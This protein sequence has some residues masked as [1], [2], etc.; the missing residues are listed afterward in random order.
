MGWIRQLKIR[1]DSITWQQVEAAAL[2]DGNLLEA[3]IAGTGSA[4]VPLLGE[5]WTVRTLGPPERGHDEH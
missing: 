1:L 5:G 4:T 3:R 2:S